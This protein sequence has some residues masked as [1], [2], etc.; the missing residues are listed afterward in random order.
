M[1]TADVYRSRRR[2]L[3][4]QIASGLIVIPGHQPSPINFAHNAYPFRQDSTFLYF[5]GPTVSDFVMLVDADGDESH[6]YGPATDALEA[7]WTGA[8][9]TVAERAEAAAFDRHGD[10]A[11]LE[12]FSEHPVQSLPAT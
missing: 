10:L 2:R 12:R 9:P 8:V 3:A 7:L 1:F 5:G 11:A 6:L 4:R